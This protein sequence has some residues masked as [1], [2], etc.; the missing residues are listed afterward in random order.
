MPKSNRDYW[1][2]KI[3]RNRERDSQS[4]EALRRD[5]WRVLTVWE[6][7]MKDQEALRTRMRQFLGSE[8]A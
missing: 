7:E 1:E 3:S 5:G 6:C 8:Y 2:S 4:Q